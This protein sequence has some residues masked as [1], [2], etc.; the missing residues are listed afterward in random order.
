MGSCGASRREVAESRN[1][2]LARL[3]VN[4]YVRG[5]PRAH[6]VRVLVSELDDTFA[7]YSP[8]LY[9]ISLLWLQR[10][11]LPRQRRVAKRLIQIGSA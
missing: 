3:G 11:R 6:P 2:D 8:S 4:H 9:I 1:R 10:S 7:V 5:L